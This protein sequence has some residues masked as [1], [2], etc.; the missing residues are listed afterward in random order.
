MPAALA[1][2]LLTSNTDGSKAADSVRDENS[3][4]NDKKKV[5]QTSSNAEEKGNSSSQKIDEPA[6]VA[7]PKVKG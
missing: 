3:G 5:S 1:Q 7:A 2:T 6:T 4:Q